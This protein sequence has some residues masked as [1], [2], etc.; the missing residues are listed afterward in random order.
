MTSRALGRHGQGRDDHRRQTAAPF[1]A[2]V[3]GHTVSL[4]QAMG[5]VATFVG[6]AAIE[7]VRSPFRRLNAFLAAPSRTCTR[8]FSL[9][10]ERERVDGR[11]E[12]L[13]GRARDSELDDKRASVAPA[14]SRSREN[15]CGRITTPREYS[16]RSSGLEH[17][18][19]TPRQGPQ[20]IHP[21]LMGPPA[22]RS[23]SLFGFS[24][25][26]LTERLLSGFCRAWSKSAGEGLAQR[27][28]SPRAP[29]VVRKS[30][31]ARRVRPCRRCVE[32]ISRHGMTASTTVASSGRPRLRMRVRAVRPVGVAVR[33]KPGR[34]ALPRCRAAG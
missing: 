29:I 23:S 5:A 17:H 8:T 22:Y 27:A 18:G 11:L 6:Q 10:F 15:A 13:V 2:Q 19:E 33:L 4:R 1:A 21:P 20:L 9:A 24:R 14:S 34:V 12:T 7:S 16:M 25:T 31:K 32:S 3:C 30:A 26:H 28:P